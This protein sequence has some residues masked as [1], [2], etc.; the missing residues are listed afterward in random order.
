MQFSWF[1][2]RP[3]GQ[4]HLLLGLHCDVSF[5]PY[6]LFFALGFNWQLY[7]SFFA[8]RFNLQLGARTSDKSALTAGPRPRLQRTC[9]GPLFPLRPLSFFRLFVGPEKI[10]SRIPAFTHPYFLYPTPHISFDLERRDPSNS[11][12]RIPAGWL[13]RTY[14]N[15]LD[16]PSIFEVPRVRGGPPYALNISFTPPPSSQPRMAVVRRNTDAFLA[17]PSIMVRIEFDTY[18]FPIS[19][20]DGSVPATADDPLNS[21]R[22]CHR[23]MRSKH[24][25]DASKNCHHLN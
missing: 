24:V 13:L 14:S 9:A 21:A 22:S 6:R 2:E 25:P 15:S 11:I 3:Q 20:G 10:S 18:I 16:V 7:P 17:S 5:I 19:F 8:L 12:S 4:A 1:Y 23:A